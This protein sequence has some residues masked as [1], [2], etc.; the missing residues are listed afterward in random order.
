MDTTYPR[1][2]L[3]DGADLIPPSDVGKPVRNTP[4]FVLKISSRLVDILFGCNFVDSSSVN[5]AWRPQYERHQ[6]CSCE[7]YVK[8]YK[9][10]GARH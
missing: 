10:L 6:Q 2:A 3:I 4:L 5:P 8:H 7:A 1:F 9:L